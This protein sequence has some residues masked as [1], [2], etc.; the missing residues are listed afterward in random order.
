MANYNLFNVSGQGLGIVYYVDGVELSSVIKAGEVRS[1]TADSLSLETLRLVAQ[2]MLISEAPLASGAGQEVVSGFPLVHRGTWNPNVRY[3]PGDVATFNGMAYI[4]FRPVFS[5]SPND[6]P[7]AWGILVPT[8]PPVTALVDRVAALEMLAPTFESR[9]RE[10]VAS[11]SYEQVSAN[12]DADGVVTTASIRW[13]DGTMGTYTTTVKN[14]TFLVVDAYT[15][16]YSGVLN[17]LV[18][19]GAVTRN[20]SGDIIA[21]PSLIVTI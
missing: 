1:L 19:Q 4:S 20:S 11:R 16:S 15:I 9:L 8:V 12:L 7:G 17:A 2:G 5:Q 18:S 10:I 14:S 13:P 3:A 6:N 21:K